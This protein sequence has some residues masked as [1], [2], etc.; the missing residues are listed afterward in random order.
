MCIRDSWYD[1]ASGGT[2]ISTGPTF[3]TPT[4][5]QSTTFYVQAGSICPSQMMAVDAIINT[6]S[7]D[8]LV[9]DTT[10]CGPGSLTL[11]A[12]DTSLVYWYNAAI[13]G[14]TLA[15]GPLFTTPVL[16]QTTTYYVQAGGQ[17]PS[18]VPTKKVPKFAQNTTSGVIF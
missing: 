3:L 5:S 8:P 1:V 13:G 16:T 17:C 7:P 10:H 14:T 18:Q 15:T 11:N 2:V 9:S 12:I 6:V 4:L